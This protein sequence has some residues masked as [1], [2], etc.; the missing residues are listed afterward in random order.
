MMCMDWGTKPNPINT[1]WLLGLTPTMK[2]FEEKGEAYM[3]WNKI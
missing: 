1:N 3:T 2:A